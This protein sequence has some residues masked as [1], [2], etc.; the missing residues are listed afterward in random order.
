MKKRE[1]NQVHRLRLQPQRFQWF[2]TC[3]INSY[4]GLFSI[5]FPIGRPQRCAGSEEDERRN[6]HHFHLS[7]TTSAVAENKGGGQNYLKAVAGRGGLEAGRR[8]R[9]LGVWEGRRQEDATALSLHKGHHARIGIRKRYLQRPAAAMDRV[10]AHKLSEVRITRNP[11][12]FSLSRSLS[13]PPMS[14][15]KAAR[16][17]KR[18]RKDEESDSEAPEEVANEQLKARVLDQQ[19]KARLAALRSAS[20]RITEIIHCPGEPASQFLDHWNA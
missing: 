15:K 10:R 6:S 12:S 18:P 11:L 5:N 8:Q 17:R 16:G 20:I 9:A 14:S 19:H 13:S 4:F 1:A 2:G 3:S 7:F